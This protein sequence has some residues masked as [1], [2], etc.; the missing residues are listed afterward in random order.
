MPTPYRVTLAVLF[1]LTL[2]AVA[3]ATVF[4]TV[5]GVVHDP[6]HRPVLGAT[7]TVKAQRSD[8]TRSAATAADGAFHMGTVPLGDY[9]VDVSVDGFET[10][11]LAITVVSDTAPVLHVQLRIAAVSEG[12]QV[13]AVPETADAGKVTPTT[14]ISRDDIAS[15]PGAG[16]T[17]SVSMITAFVPGSYLTHDQLHVRGGHQVSWLVD[18]VPVPNTNIASN[19]GPQFDPKDADYLEVHRGSYDAEYGDRTYAVFNVVPRTGFER[20]NDAEVVLNGGSFS[21]SNDQVSV[22]GHTER[23]AYYA[24][25]SGNQSN[26]GLQTP[27]ADLIHDRQTGLGGFGTLIFNAD[28]NNQIRLVTSVR[29]DTYQVPNDLDAQAAGIADVERESDAFVNLTWVRSFS[30]GALLTVSPFYHRNTARYDGGTGDVPVSTTDHRASE[31]LGAQ[32]TFGGSSGRHQWQV[33]FYGFHQQDDQTLSVM[34][35][36]GSN[37]DFSVR[38]RPSGNLLTAFAQDT[39]KMASWL[40]VIGGVRQTHFSGG[41]AE[42][43]TSPRAGVSI[44]LPSLGWTV[45]AFY[46]RFYQG[47]PLLTASGPLLDFVTSQN[48]ALIPLRGERDE[49]IQAGVAMPV[50]G[51]MIDADVFRTKATNFFDHNSVGNSNVFFPLTIDAARIRGTEVTVRSP[52]AWKTAHFHLAYSYQIAEGLGGISGGLTDFSP[53][54]DYFPLDHDQ[55]HTLSA[56][57]DARLDRGVFAGANLYY[58]SGFP[59]SGGPARLPSH[60]TMDVVIGKAFGDRVSL[61]LTALNITNQRVMLDNSVTFGGTHFSTPREVFAEVRYRF[62]Y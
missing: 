35:N 27:V 57:L 37:D 61:S 29:G 16:R 47:P 53:P 33:G 45:R 39:F 2:S 11:R 28:P 3:G 13:S 43:A 52:K 24:S 30:S 15:T 26:L 19:V 41:L 50:K 51:W 14:L 6:Q 44:L 20:N 34:F 5:K 9:T 7:V 56:G 40:S 8:W 31:Y 12:V 38:Q 22:G 55:R 49:E 60:V 36:D 18:G 58:G 59:D 62:H 42:D 54:S 32:A 10:A 23:F 1:V 4:G 46:G 17:N 48:L 25:A 21:Q